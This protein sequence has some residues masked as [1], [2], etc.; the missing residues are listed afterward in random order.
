MPTP[1]KRSTA[2]STPAPGSDPAVSVSLKSLR[3]PPLDVTL[4]A[5][6]LTT[7]ML[8]LKQTVAE[9]IG[10]KNTD[11]IRLLYKK[12][13]CTDSKTIKDVIGEETLKEVEFAVMV[14]GGTGAVAEEE[15]TKDGE[16]QEDKEDVAM[17]DAPIAPVAQGKSGAEVLA[18]TEFWDD[19]RGFLMQRV[20]DQAVAESAT[21]IFEDAWKEKGTKAR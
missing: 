21:K 1:M 6:P 17:A 9:K 10:A 19:L 16:A 18:E 11:K 12:K 15:K 5:Q 7:S 14:L 4:P 13:P 3:N 20:R 8:D 2:T